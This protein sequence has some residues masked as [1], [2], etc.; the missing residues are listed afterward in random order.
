[1][2]LR[3]LVVVNPAAPNLD[4]ALLEAALAEA[5]PASDEW[6]TVESVAG[7]EAVAHV[8]AELE[9]AHHD[10]AGRVLAAGGD[11]T[12]SLVADALT[13]DL[14]QRFRLGIVPLGTANVLARELGVPLE[15]RAAV[16]L[17]IGGP[18]T[19][20]LD[21]IA[22]G[23][24]R[25]LT[26]V[27]VGL[28]AAMIASTTRQAQIDHGRLAYVTALVRE[29]T[30]GR[31]HRFVLEIDG[32]VRRVRAWQVVLANARTFGMAPFTWG[33]DITA[34]DGVLDLCV[35]DVRRARDTAALAWRILARR[36]R[37]DARARYYRVRRE[38]TIR[39]S[40]AL[41]V[42]GDGEILGETP[43]T[44]RVAPAFVTVVIPVVATDIASADAATRRSESRPTP[45]PDPVAVEQAAHDPHWRVRWTAWDAGA[46]FRINHL[47]APAWVDAAMRWAS[48]LMDLGEAWVLMAIVLAF[49]HRPVSPGI[50][51]R[52]IVPLWVAMLI[53]NF[54][55][56]A[57]FRR[58][59]PFVVHDAVR[60][61]ILKPADTSFP[62]GHTAAAFAGVVLLA[63]FAPA[64]TAWMV[65]YAVIVGGSRVYL[66][67][68]YPSDVAMGAVLGVALAAVLGASFALLV[69]A[70]PFAM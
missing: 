70:A 56:K 21:A 40:S 30:G 50:A 25:Y 16:A 10:G 44:L 9:R 14:A 37:R 34:T 6:R 68:H 52:V 63:P 31:A 13:P 39:A 19:A 57:L 58:R 49:A 1:M 51:L 47:H 33:P 18:G 26:Q 22:L 69:G 60:V 28:D 7:A 62:S 8:R 17:A 29:A 24:R 67:V 35:F 64:A 23:E 3:A 54:P 11:G 20:R 43:V 2:P 27:G 61:R 5:L 45:A 4:R 38:V 12:V 53:V 41:P 32:R 36:H 42:Q 15:P 66:G 46:F 59:R 55:I 48:R 65:A